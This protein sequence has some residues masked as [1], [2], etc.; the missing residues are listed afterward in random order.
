[1]LTPEQAKQLSE[2]QRIS[3]AKSLISK[4]V[5]K[6][7][8]REILTAI[9]TTSYKVSITLK[10]RDCTDADDKLRWYLAALWYEDVR[11]SSDFPWYCETYEWST[12]IKFRVPR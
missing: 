5:E 8:D 10:A 11:V 12:T 3:I 1:M 7:L 4:K 6:I 9:A 2:K